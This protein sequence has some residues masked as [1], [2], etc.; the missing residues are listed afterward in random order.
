MQNHLKTQENAP[1]FGLA[2]SED[3]VQVH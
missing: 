1:L 3:D 2:P